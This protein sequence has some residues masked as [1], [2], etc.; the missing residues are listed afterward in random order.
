MLNVWISFYKIQ[1]TFKQIRLES[2]KSKISEKNP[3]HYKI[4]KFLEPF[5]FYFL[6]L[7]F[8]LSP[9]SLAPHSFFLSPFVASLEPSPSYYFWPPFDHAKMP[10]RC[11]CFQLSMSNLSL[12][13]NNPAE[14]PIPPYR[15]PFSSSFTFY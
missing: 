15:K 9:I 12:V 13:K 7:S 3:N 6:F 4:K 1:T 5:D 2:V 11:H 10:A 14:L 8:F